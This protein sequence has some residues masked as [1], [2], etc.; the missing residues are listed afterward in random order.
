MC[1][2]FACAHARVCGCVVCMCV[3]CVCVWFV[4]TFCVCMCAACMPSNPHAQLSCERP[5]FHERHAI[6]RSSPPLE[7]EKDAQNTK[8]QKLSYLRKVPTIKEHV[9][10]K[11]VQS[12][13]A[14]HCQ[15][16]FFIFPLHSLPR[17]VNGT[18]IA[19]LKVSEWHMHSLSPKCLTVTCMAYLQSV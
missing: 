9:Q 7:S 11:D 13:A 17:P 15:I 1:S 4:H 12:L 8:Y 3:A 19:Y 5:F 6:C 16:G 14:D 2:C 10:A 18:C